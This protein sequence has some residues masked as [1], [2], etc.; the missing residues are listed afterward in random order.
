MKNILIIIL[1]ISPL[2]TIAQD[3]AI[4]GET[5]WGFST[6]PENATNPECSTIVNTF[7]WRTPRWYV[8][9][10]LG[11]ESIDNSVPSPFFNDA[12]L[13]IPEIYRTDTY[14]GKDFEVEDGW[15]LIIDGITQQQG[16]QTESTIVYLALYNKYTGILRIFGTHHNIGNNASDYD[17]A[18]IKLK[19]DQ[20]GNKELTGLLHPTQ[21]IAQPLD[22]KSIKAIQRN[23]KLTDVSPVQFFYADF[24]IAYDPCTCFSDQLGTIVVD[25]EVVDNR[26]VKLYGRAVSISRTLEEIVGSQS[27][28]SEDFLTNIYAENGYNRIGSAISSNTSFYVNAS[29]QHGAE[30]RATGFAT[31]A[32]K[33]YTNINMNDGEVGVFQAGEAI[34]FSPETEINVDVSSASFEAKILPCS[35]I[36]SREVPISDDDEI[37]IVD[38]VDKVNF[39]CL[40]DLILKPNPFRE[41]LILEIQSNCDFGKGVLF[42]QNTLG[43]IVREQII[44]YESIINLNID[45][46]NFQSG[47]YY[48]IFVTD[49]GRI[50]R[51]A[52]KI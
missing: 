51:K 35:S 24:P 23:S 42:I 31:G 10:Y 13:A 32:L 25:F 19:F 5:P 8:P 43:E 45:S 33:L 3:E 6:N 28:I 1:L 50:I 39:G 46:S 44:S 26:E 4:C 47:I 38:I 52:L 37:P 2:W 21:Q 20:T 48:I 30:I 18:V 7:D 27:Q 17:Y 16:G 41:N 40:E 29:Y 49:N 11:K 9:F 15:E 12:N 22:Q 36:T 34:I 14:S